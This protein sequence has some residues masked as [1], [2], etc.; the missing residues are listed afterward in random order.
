[1]LA[2]LEFKNAKVNHVTFLSA[3]NVFIPTFYV[4]K[5]DVK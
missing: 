2:F 1:M 5:N 3:K 4:V